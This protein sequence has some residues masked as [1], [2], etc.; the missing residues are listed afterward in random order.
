MQCRFEAFEFDHRF[1]VNPGSATGAFMPCFG[2]SAKAKPAQDK[3]DEP[4]A[5][6]TGN[7]PAVALDPT[8]SFTLLDIQGNVVVVYVYQLVSG[9]VKVE[10][11]E[12]RAHAQT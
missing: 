2:S 10:K 12:F 8:P 11:I 5:D 3:T 4:E 9:E 6:S 7:E 1:F